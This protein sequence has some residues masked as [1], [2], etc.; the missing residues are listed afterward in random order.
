MNA[1]NAGEPR[2]TLTL[3]ALVNTRSLYLH[4]EGEPKN[5]VFEQ[6]QS[7]SNRVG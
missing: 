4:F 6:V 5:R 1:P 3:S 7:G 2:I